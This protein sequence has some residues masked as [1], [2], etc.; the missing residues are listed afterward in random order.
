MSPCRHV[1]QTTAAP[2]STPPERRARG[3][4]TGPKFS[5]WTLILYLNTSLVLHA[6]QRETSHLPADMRGIIAL[7]IFGFTWMGPTHALSKQTNQ[8]AAHV[9]AFKM[10]ANILSVSSFCFLPSPYLA[11]AIFQHSHAEKPVLTPTAMREY[12]GFSYP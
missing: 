9:H 12:H 5:H 3:I 7:F 4:R 6:P 11:S 10:P 2:T 1:N 8:E